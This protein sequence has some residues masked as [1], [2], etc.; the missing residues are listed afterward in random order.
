MIQATMLLTP[1][2]LYL[3]PHS[4][5]SFLSPS[6]CSTRREHWKLLSSLKTTVEGLVSTNNPNV[7]SRYGG[8]QRLQKDMNNILS[9]GLKN[10]QVSRSDRCHSP[11]CNCLFC[12][13]C[14][15]SR[16]LISVSSEP[17]FTLAELQVKVSICETLTFGVKCRTIQ[18]KCHTQ[19]IDRCF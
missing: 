14:K 2:L 4:L 19:P 13:I 6:C 16:L 7:W 3:L 8:L 5:T 1:A 11:F 18:E 12:A 10:E 9:H 15:Q 17:C